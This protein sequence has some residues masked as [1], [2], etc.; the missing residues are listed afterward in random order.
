MKAAL[1][2]RVSTEDRAVSLDAQ[3][4]GARAWCA[5]EGHSVVAVY[6]D[7]GVSGAEW[8]NRPGVAALLPDARRTPRPWDVLVVRDLDRLGRDSLRTPLLVSDLNDAGVSVVEW[9]TGRTVELDGAQLLV[10]QIRAYSAAEE[11]KALSERVR[12]ALRQRAERGD[13]AGAKVY[14]YRHVREGTRVRYALDEAEAAV[15]R[16][17]YERAAAGESGRAIARALTA[18]GVPPPRATVAGAWCSSTVHAICRSARYRGE[19]SWGRQSSAYKGGSRVAVERTGVVGQVPAVV[20]AVLWQRAQARSA[21]V[22]LTRPSTEPRYLLVGRVVCD[23]C[24]GPIAAWRTARRSTGERPTAYRCLRHASAGAVACS[25]SYCRPAAPY[26]RGVLA[27]I[28][29]A[30]EPARVREAVAYARSLQEAPA[31]D[32]R[33]EEL[34]A[35]IARAE[36]RAARLGAALEHGDDDVA[37][38]VARRRAARTEADTAR[39]ELAALGAA[40]PVLDLA[41]ERELVA[42]AADVRAA[43]AEGYDRATAGD[44]VAMR[45]LRGIVAAA[46]PVPLRARVE[47]R[48]LVMVGE[49]RPGGCITLAET[50]LCP[51]QNTL[52]HWTVPVRAAV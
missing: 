48:E 26:D 12:V 3:E 28:G 31:R 16:E 15:V 11:R 33:R 6:R 8:T 9:S 2:L 40:A 21:A 30:L 41:V 47:G 25:A 32:T 22:A 49:L 19:A 42:L 36:A 14:G 17:I 38:L 1:Y 46:L 23:H 29:G 51:G 20:D 39:A 7:D 4:E 50:R 10:V 34:A 24:G 35:T 37:A 18:R 45:A 52:P 43:L 13:V 5:R 27:A 44:A